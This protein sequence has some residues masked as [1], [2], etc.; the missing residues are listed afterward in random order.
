MG[1]VIGQE[2]SGKETFSSD[3]VMYT[4]PNTG[5]TVSIPIAIYALPGSNPDRGVIPDMIVKY[6]ID[7]FRGGKDKDLEA[8]RDL[9]RR[10]F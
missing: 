2:T 9:I 3:P 7:D 5:L 1:T 10:K 4:L 8:V 6:S